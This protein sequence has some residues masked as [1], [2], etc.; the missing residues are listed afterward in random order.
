MLPR[1]LPDR[2]GRPIVFRVAFVASGAPVWP[3][4]QQP[5]PLEPVM[6]YQLDQP[7]PFIEGELRRLAPVAD[8]RRVLVA[9]EQAGECLQ[10]YGLID[11]G[12]SHS[13]MTRHERVSGAASP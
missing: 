13:E 5:V 2:G 11:A 3:P 10:I 12:M 8:P 9:V 7:V 4:R 1:E 6:R